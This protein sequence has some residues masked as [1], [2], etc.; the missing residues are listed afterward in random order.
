MSGEQF[1]YAV[2]HIG[3]YVNCY[4]MQIPFVKYSLFVPFDFVDSSRFI[5][6][7]KFVARFAKLDLRRKKASGVG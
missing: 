5:D 2:I 3:V 1:M 6:Q 7:R 4:M